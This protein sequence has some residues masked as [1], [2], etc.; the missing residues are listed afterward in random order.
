M[1]M[2]ISRLYQLKCINTVRIYDARHLSK[3]FQSAGASVYY[4][5]VSNL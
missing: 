5:Y 1:V 3:A 2:V 4:M